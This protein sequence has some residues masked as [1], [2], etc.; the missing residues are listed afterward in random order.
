MTSWYQAERKKDKVSREQAYTFELTNTEG[1]CAQFNNYLYSY[2]TAREKNR[3]LYVYD[4]NNAISSNFSLIDSTFLCPS[5][6]KITDPSMLQFQKLNL[7]Q[8]LPITRTM[9]LSKIKAAASSLFDIKPEMLT[10][11]NN[12]LEKYSLPGRFD[13]GVHLK[14]GQ[15]QTVNINSYV[16]SLKQFQKIN[17]IKE[18]SIFVMTDS[19]K[20]FESLKV[21][22]DVSWKL[23]T[24][25][26]PEQ[27]GYNHNEF[28]QLPLR[29]RRDAYTKFLSELLIMRNIR[30]IICTLSSNVG[31]WLYVNIHEDSYLKSMDIQTYSPI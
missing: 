26:G 4:K 19:Y 1:F 5:T 6:V 20:L 25:D 3:T 16:D 30:A 7:G 18:M 31:R 17:S 28:R 21:K 14:S 27:T 22:A 13:I 15:T 9:P 2:L 24:V 23:Y 29:Q 8:T 10:E 12:F 11:C